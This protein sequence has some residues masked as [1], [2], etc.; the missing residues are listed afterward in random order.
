MTFVMVIVWPT[1]YGGGLRQSVG[2]L[3]ESLFSM[4]ALSGTVLLA[5]F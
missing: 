3:L 1:S 5:P 2:E 4:L